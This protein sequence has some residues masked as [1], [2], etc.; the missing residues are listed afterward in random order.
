MSTPPAW[1]VSAV[2]AAD[3]AT[4]GLGLQE[5]VTIERAGA[6]SQTGDVDFDTDHETVLALVERKAGKLQTRDGQELSFRAIV[7]FLRPISFNPQDRITLSDGM[8]GPVIEPEGGLAN[9]DTGAPYMR[10]VHLG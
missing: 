1:L 7:G 2:A 10:T 9:P 3:A 4:Q 8:T 6:V 5:A